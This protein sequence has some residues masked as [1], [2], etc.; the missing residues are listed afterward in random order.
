MPGPRARLIRQSCRLRPHDGEKDDVANGG[1]LGEQHDEPVDADADAGCG[2]KS[3]L[4]RPHEGGVGRMGLDIASRGRRGLGLKTFVLL[5]GIVEFAVTVGQLSPGDD[6]LEAI[7]DGRVRHAVAGQRRHLGRVVVDEDRTD[8]F[9]HEHLVVEL[10][11]QLPGRP[12]G[13]IRHLLGV[14]HRP[15]L[16]YGH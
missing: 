11:H 3:V 14:A 8:R 16:L 1:H 9:V 13:Q 7:R 2:R 12:V 5:V 10:E 6:E 4:E 15:E